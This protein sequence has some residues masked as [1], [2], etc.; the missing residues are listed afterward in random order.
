MIENTSQLSWW[1]LVLPLMMERMYGMVQSRGLPE[2]TVI[3]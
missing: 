2:G 3:L 1:G